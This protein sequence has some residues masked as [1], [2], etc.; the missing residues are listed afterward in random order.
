MDPGWVGLARSFV[1][2]ASRANHARAHANSGI[3]VFVVGVVDRTI[4][5]NL[6]DLCWPS[7]VVIAHDAAARARALERGGLVFVAFRFA[8]F[9]WGGLVEPSHRICRRG[10]RFGGLN[11]PGKSGGEVEEQGAAAGVHGFWEL[12]S[13]GEVRNFSELSSELCHEMLPDPGS[14][15]EPFEF[16]KTGSCG[17]ID[18]L[19]TDEVLEKVRHRETGFSPHSAAS[20]IF[21]SWP[22]NV[23]NISYLSSLI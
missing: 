19:E 17:S 5:Q 1:S 11:D 21:G 14:C 22:E 7:E 4:R 6:D 10:V 16:S 8:G 23:S 9:R 18:P 2:D 13:M 20:S 15:A 3:A 12:Y